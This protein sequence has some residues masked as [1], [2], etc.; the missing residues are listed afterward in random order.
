MLAP[1]AAYK[2]T[3]CGSDANCAYNGRCV[4]SACVCSPQWTGP[5]CEQLRLLPASPRAGFRSPHRPNSPL[6]SW[7]GSVL[8]DATDGL[9]TSLAAHL[10]CSSTSLKCSNASRNTLEFTGLYHM[11]AAEMINQCGI[12]YWEPNSRVVHATAAAAEGPYEYADTVLAPHRA[13]NW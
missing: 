1:L 4:A 10:N 11:F 8:Y 3:A 6:S 5:R 12:D 13:C 9:H 7:G 2:A